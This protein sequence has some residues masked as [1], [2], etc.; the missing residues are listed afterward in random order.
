MRK[1]YPSV[2]PYLMTPDVEELVV[3]IQKVF[4]GVEIFRS[5]G[6]AGGAHIEMRIGDSV[7]MMGG[8]ADGES[9]PAALHVYVADV[10]VVYAKALEAGATSIA[11]PMQQGDPDRRGGV[12]DRFGNQWWIAT[13][14]G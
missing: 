14:M 6:S 11:E 4:D 10:D 3:F 9:F 8:A 13:H 7:V 1:G 2:S 5:I 12:L